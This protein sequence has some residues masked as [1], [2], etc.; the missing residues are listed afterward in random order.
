MRG[1][2]KKIGKE[3]EGKKGVKGEVMVWLKEILIVILLRGEFLGKMIVSE[4]GRWGRLYVMERVVEIMIMVSVM[5]SEG[6]MVI[7]KVMM[8][9]EE[10]GE[11][12]E[13][14]KKIGEERIGVKYVKGK[15]LNEDEDIEC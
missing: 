13:E 4:Y 12:N 6:E 2:K 5:R 14:V 1:N 9:E 10:M 15:I 3:I 11:K 8:I 7:K